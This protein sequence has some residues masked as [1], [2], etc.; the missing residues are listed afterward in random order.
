MR[1]R[2]RQRWQK[3]TTLPELGELVARWLEGTIPSQPGWQPNY[4]PD[5][6]AAPLTPALAAAC[7]A[8]YVTYSSQ[9]GFAGP[10]FDGATWRQR[11]AVE[12][13]IGH[14]DCVRLYEIIREVPG[15]TCVAIMPSYAGIGSY[16]IPVSLREAKETCSFGGGLDRAD[17]EELY[18]EDC[19]PDM[20]AV[21]QRA[22]QLTIVD[23][24]FNRDSLLW[25][26]LERFAETP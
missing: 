16:R 1:K 25:P 8:G 11:A 15:L 12:G 26:A 23:T 7:R 13:F 3:A 9:P 20:V 10:G 21:L 4:G 2:D 17:I 18:G 5:E 6:E 14:D 19:S 24:E 22:L